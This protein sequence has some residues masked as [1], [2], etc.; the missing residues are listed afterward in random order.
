MTLTRCIVNFFIFCLLIPCV[1]SFYCFPN[2]YSQQDECSK[3][4]ISCLNC[5]FKE[6][7]Q[8]GNKT[9][10]T[11]TVLDH[12]ECS[13][14]RTFKKE[15]DCLYC[16]QLPKSKYTCGRRDNCSSNSSPQARIITTCT[17]DAEVHCF[18]NRTF[19]KSFACNWTSGTRWSTAF[20]LSITLGGFGADR[21]YLGHWEE[22]L[23]KFFSFG[24][25]GVWTLVD[26]VLVGIGY[27]TP[28]DGS[29][30]IF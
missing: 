21:F 26:I 27:I 20:L 7:C 9:L 3:V 28:A 14:E 4:S 22:G 23:G 13:G 10:G 2:N 11:C 29:L 6:S 12:I 24:G 30:Y 5:T 18:G 16:Y 25:L 15:F 17:V 8:N 1:G 19:L